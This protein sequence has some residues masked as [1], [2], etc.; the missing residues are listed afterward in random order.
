M[1]RSSSSVYNSPDI[2]NFDHETW[3]MAHTINDI[4]HNFFSA[5]QTTQLAQQ[6]VIKTKN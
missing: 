4:W 5:A 3:P 6:F 1:K 2:T